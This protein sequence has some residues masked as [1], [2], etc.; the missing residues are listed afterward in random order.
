MPLDKGTGLRNDREAEADYNRL[1][2]ERQARWRAMDRLET[3]Q[4]HCRGLALIAI[5]ALVWAMVA[6]VKLL[7]CGCGK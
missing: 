5:A 2:D 4:M 6:T 7:A 3:I 1:E